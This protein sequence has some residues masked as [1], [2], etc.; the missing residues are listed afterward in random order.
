MTPGPCKFCGSTDTA[1]ALVG[2]ATHTGWTVVCRSC[3][4]LLG[5]REGAGAAWFPSP[6]EAVGAWNSGPPSKVEI[7]TV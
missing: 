7:I 5:R 2:N 3:G 6:S 4:A 1:P